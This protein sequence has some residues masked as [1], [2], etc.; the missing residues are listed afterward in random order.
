MGEGIKEKIAEGVVKREDVF[1]VTKVFCNILKNVI[2]K[3]Y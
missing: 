2:T 1:V 3:N